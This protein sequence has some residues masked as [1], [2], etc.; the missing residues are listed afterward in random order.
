MDMDTAPKRLEAYGGN[1]SFHTGCL[2]EAVVSVKNAQEIRRLIQEANGTGKPLIPVSSGGAHRKG[3]STPDVPGCTMLDLSGM[4]QILSI[5]RRHRMAVVEPGV[6]YP[7]LQK[8][9][10]EEGLMLAQP[11]AQ[12][13]GK[14]VAAAILERV[15]NTNVNRNWNYVDPI[16]CCGVIWGDGVQMGTGESFGGSFDPRDQQALGKFQINGAGPM[17]VDYSRL[18]TGSMGTMGVVAWTALHC[19]PLPERRRLYY[20]SAADF[21]GIRDFLYGLL[22]KRCGDAVFAM[23]RTQ[24]AALLGAPDRASALPKWTVVVCLDSRPLSP[25]ARIDAYAKMLLQIAGETGVSVCTQLLGLDDDHALRRIFEG[26]PEGYWKDAARGASADVFFQTTLDRAQDFLMDMERTAAAQGMDAGQIGV[27]IQP[28]HTG[29][30]CQMEFTIPWAPGE[31]ET[32]HAM[33]DR[34]S[35]VC[36]QNGAYFQEPYGGWAKL[37]FERDPKGADMLRRIKHIFDPRGILNP[38]KLCF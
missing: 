28:R 3:G 30:S 21:G 17:M 4:D 14:S 27:T 20:A 7:K 10:A 29:T 16:S 35:A 25:S 23:N 31:E 26:S 22:H 8:A 9:L 2:P 37:Q 1:T 38:G 5:S 34:L 18:L 32:A 11:L 6:T 24:L 36:A 13:A 15:P 12:R 19:V 33:F